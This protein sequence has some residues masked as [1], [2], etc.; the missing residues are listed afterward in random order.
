MSNEEVPTKTT[1][2]DLMKP[3]HN[4][5]TATRAVHHHTTNVLVAE[6]EQISSDSPPVE[7][8]RTL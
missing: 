2:S 1:T 5:P 7:S 8:F 3:G 4:R 6:Q